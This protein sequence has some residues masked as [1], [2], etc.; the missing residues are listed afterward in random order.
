MKPQ[1]G[2]R[3][4]IDALKVMPYPVLIR[5][6]VS[7]LM[8][9]CIITAVLRAG[10]IEETGRVYILFELLGILLVL[11]YAMGVYCLCGLVDLS[12]KLR[13]ALILLIIVVIFCCANILTRGSRI[14]QDVY[15]NV[16]VAM[17]LEILSR[18]FNVM[19]DVVNAAVIL[20]TMLGFK[21]AVLK[22]GEKRQLSREELV[23]GQPYY[24]KL[25]KHLEQLGIIYFA[26]TVV[27]NAAVLFS[28]EADSIWSEYLLVVSL[29]VWTL[30]EFA[31][32][33]ETRRAA[34]FIWE[35]YRHRIPAGNGASD[36]G[37]R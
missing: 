28:N 10:S 27:M 37:G 6:I 11:G 32:F 13:T 8:F 17:T 12:D 31:L 4:N 2:T 29:L 35:S 30:I 36:M 34:S 7:C 23:S 16:Q 24:K 5:A 18:L 1:R 22:A 3:I 15:G 33:F 19:E 9:L 26:G 25:S 20:L 21:E 14:Y